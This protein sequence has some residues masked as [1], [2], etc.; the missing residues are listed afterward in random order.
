M[1]S[2]TLIPTPPIVRVCDNRSQQV[3]EEE[4]TSFQI[5]LVCEKHSIFV[6]TYNDLLL[7]KSYSEGAWYECTVDQI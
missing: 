6:K 1:K 4:V 3:C 7:I 2:F 5:Y